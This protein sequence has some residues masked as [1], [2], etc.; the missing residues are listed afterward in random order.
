[1]AWLDNLFP[2]VNQTP[3]VQ[4][5]GNVKRTEGGNNPFAQPIETG[6]N[7]IP[8]ESMAYLNNATTGSV[9]KNG[10]GHSE[11]GLMKPYLA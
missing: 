3:N 11:F 1:M 9:Y 10:L 4:W 6:V 5:G 2:P 8:T 7:S